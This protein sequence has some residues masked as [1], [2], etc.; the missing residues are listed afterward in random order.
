MIFLSDFRKLASDM[1]NQRKFYHRLLSERY[2]WPGYER[3]T[4]DGEKGSM[5]IGKISTPFYEPP[6]CHF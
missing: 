3:Y 2:L 6:N 1:V 5:E 4:S